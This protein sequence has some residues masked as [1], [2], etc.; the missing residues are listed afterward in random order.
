MTKSRVKL[1]AKWLSLI[2]FA[3][4]AASCGDRGI[5]DPDE[6]VRVRFLAFPTPGR[7]APFALA[8]EDGSYAARNVDFEF[9]GSFDS[10]IALLEAGE[11]EIAQALCSE[12]MSRIS[13][14]AD[15]LIIAVR[16]A[17]FPV[18]TVSL[19]E[20][21]I[22]TVADYAD[23][24]WGESADNDAELAVMPALADINGFDSS[25][26]EIINLAFEAK[27]P[28][29]IA[30]EVDF[31]TAWYGS[32]YVTYLLAAES[33]GIDLNLIRWSEFGL[34]IYGQCFVARASWVNDNRE[35]AA[36][37]VSVTKAAYQNAI[38]NQDRAVAATLNSEIF[39]GAEED[40]VR[41]GWMQS[42]ELI[43][44]A[45]TAENGVLWIDKDKL[46]RTRS[47]VAPMFPADRLDQAYT[48]DFVR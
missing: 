14:G 1:P 10:T 45:N 33:Q 42:S 2:L 43:E 15:L 13:L 25:S 16:D 20:S 32:G 26:I 30:G 19:P 41:L 27:L 17:I 8:V 46:E 11:G 40:S 31:V 47:L 39:E 36:A 5:S 34:D 21:G 22:R 3:L 37:F 24:K 35:G 6:P 23:K 48:L 29:L 12:A 4:I 9:V 38:A 28:A 44:D 18:A 7:S